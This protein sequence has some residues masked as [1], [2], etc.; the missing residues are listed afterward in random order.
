MIKIRIERAFGNAEHT[1]AFEEVFPPFGRDNDLIQHIVVT[2]I[3][4][5]SQGI[6]YGKACL[7]GIET[8]MAVSRVAGKNLVLKDRIVM[9]MLE[10]RKEHLLGGVRINRI[11]CARAPAVSASSSIACGNAEG[12]MPADFPIAQRSA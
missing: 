8:Q 11:T 9:Q 5:P 2:D 6:V 1:E 10:R 7:L 12:V 3:L 4:K